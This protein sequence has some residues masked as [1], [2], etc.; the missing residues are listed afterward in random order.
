[1]S[2]TASLIVHE[3]FS[4]IAD[5]LRSLY[6][7]TTLAAQVYVTI[8]AGEQAQCDAL[9]EAFPQVSLIV[10]ATPMGFAANHNRVLRLAETPYVA[11]LNDDIILHEAALDKLVAYLETHP[12][13]GLVGP[14]LLNAD[15]SPQVSQYGDPSLPR[16]LYKISGLARLTR[17]GS[18]LGRWLR[19]G[20]TAD[21]LGIESVL[22]PPS[23]RSVPVVKG[24]VMVVRREAYQQ[25]GLMDESTLM[26]GEEVDWHLRL[27]QAGW[28]IA[29][30]PAARVTHYGEGHEAL[31]LEGFML[32]EDRKAILNYTLKHHPRWQAWVVRAAIVLC[33]ALGGLAWLPFS[34]SRARA[35]FA[36]MHMGATWQR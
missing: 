27:R 33:H 6:A 35:H 3:D 1:M 13:V 10:N 26:F 15:G 18:D 31:K 29:I 32:T 12:G 30:E 20:R 34:R 25:A 14:Q 11:L 23:A 19:T 24:A 36:T 8:N 16:M 5:T 7:S 17:Q 4:H 21:L 2:L 22:A 28:Q 9:G